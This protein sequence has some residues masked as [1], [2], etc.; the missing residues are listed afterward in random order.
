MALATGDMNRDGRADLVSLGFDD[1]AA[2]WVL[3]V[4]LGKANG[5]IGPATTTVL[6]P[7]FARS[8]ALADLKS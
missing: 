6:L 2:S 7:G 1:A 3:Q 5:A 4:S 8:L